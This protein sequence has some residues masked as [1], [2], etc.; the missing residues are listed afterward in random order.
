MTKMS[1]YN[2][3]QECPSKNLDEKILF[4]EKKLRELTKCP[5]GELHRIK[6]ILYQFKSTFKR[7][8]AAANYTETRFLKSNEKW[9]NNSIKFDICT[10][11]KSGRPRKKFNESSERSKRRKTKDLREQVPAEQLT[12]AAQM[13]QRAEGN[14]EVS[15][16]IKDVTLTPTRAKKFRKVMSSANKNKITKHSPSEALAIFVEGDFTRRQWEILHKA[17]RSIY[18]C[19]SAIQQ[20]KQECYPKEQSISVTETC[21]DIILQDLLDHTSLRLCKYLA[22]VIETCTVEEKNNLQLITKWGCDGSQQSQYKQ[23]FEN[24]TD[25]DANIFQSSLVPLRL[26]TYTT[27]PKRTLW[28]NPVPSSPRYCRPIRIRFVHE[29]K[30]VTNEEMKY[31]ERQERNLKKTEISTTS[32]VLHIR[33]ILLPTM[34]DAKICNAATNTASTMRCYICGQTSKDFNNLSQRK[35]INPETL[36][37]GLSILHARIRFFESLLHLSYKLTIKKWQARSEIEKKITKERKEE[38]QK[39][40]RDEMGL[41]V[42]IPKAGF[43]NTNDGNTSRRFFADPDTASRITGIDKNLIQRFKVILETMSS[44]YTIDVE[45]FGVYT[46]DTAK[47]YV[48]LYGWHPMSPTVHKILIHGAV[49]IS[50]CILPIGQLSEEAAEARNKHFKRYRLNFSRKFSRVTCNRDILN[51]LLLTS[52]PLLSSSRPQPRKKSKP[53]SSETISLLLPETQYAQTESS[54][55]EEDDVSH[56][57]DFDD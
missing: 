49:V 47:L 1:L 55:E 37:F 53:F 7:K 46:Y 4:L 50:H 41:L 8:W 29:T 25:S 21:A 54:D 34:V 32:G 5:D 48:H 10:T 24:M 14:T 33:H 31:I 2:I 40:F 43:G 44:G 45:K 38:I 52:D 20:A 42:D 23:K 16:I 12:Y 18:P 27:G 39:A 26:Q 36:R 30:D 35:D 17:N 22:E 3:I 56:E 19:Y 57:S 6:R 13:C 28:Q 51:R 9:L 15:K 11:K